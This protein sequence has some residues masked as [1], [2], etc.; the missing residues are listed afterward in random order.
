M[1]GSVSESPRGTDLLDT[2]CSAQCAEYRM[3]E[4]SDT[5]HH[6]DR[7]LPKNHD[8]TKDM[9]QEFAGYENNLN[10]V[11]D[12]TQNPECFAKYVPE[13]AQRAF[14]L[15]KRRFAHA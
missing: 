15:Y 7:E 11:R 3:Q 8:L 6:D 12:L 5:T 10:L 14:A 13:R 2:H 4:P 1:T 9:K